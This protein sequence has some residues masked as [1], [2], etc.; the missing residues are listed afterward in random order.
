MHKNQNTNKI[1]HLYF[2]K[3]KIDKRSNYFCFPTNAMD[4]PISNLEIPNVPQGERE[5]EILRF[6]EKFSQQI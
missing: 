1:L 5:S 3:K 6:D 2:N 4:E